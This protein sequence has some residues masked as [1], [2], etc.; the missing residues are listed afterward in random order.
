MKF[1]LFTILVSLSLLT[2]LA[3]AQSSQPQTTTF[4]GTVDVK[5][6]REA[7]EKEFRNPQMSPLRP[8]DFAS[9]QGLNYFPVDKD[10]RV[11]A[12]FV[13]TPEEKFFMMPT[14][15]GVSRKYVKIG[16]LNFKLSG[17]DYALNV[18]QSERNLTNEKFK[19][20]KNSL[21]VPFR[22]LTSGKETYGA[23]RYISVYA[24]K[25]NSAE[26]I[27]DFN[28]AYNPSCAYGSGEFSCPIPPQEN[29]LQTEIRAGEKS[30]LIK[31]DI[32]QK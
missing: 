31:K 28:L 20:Y 1:L 7:R 19:E 29:F 22:D 17:K 6:F 2:G 25:E 27:L 10:Y 24:P 13:A 12:K 32:T 16:I 15:S 18:Y 14:S 8:Q 30:Y 26:V 23:G 9:F 5:A 3:A 4:Y 11:A 21:F